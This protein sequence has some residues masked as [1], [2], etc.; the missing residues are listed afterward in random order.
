MQVHFSGICNNIMCDVFHC[1][2]DSDY[3]KIILSNLVSTYNNVTFGIYH[4]NFF[5]NW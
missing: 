4:N 1:V 3:T 5:A 2:L